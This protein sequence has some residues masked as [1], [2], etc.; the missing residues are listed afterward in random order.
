MPLI[1]AQLRTLLISSSFSTSCLIPNVAKT[2]FISY[3]IPLAIRINFTPFLNTMTIRKRSLKKVEIPP[4]NLL[5]NMTSCLGTIK[6][7]VFHKLQNWSYCRIAKLCRNLLLPCCCPVKQCMIDFICSCAH[8]II[9]LFVVSV[10]SLEELASLFIFMCTRGQICNE[11]YVVL[12]VQR[13][14]F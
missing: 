10:S 2:I 3:L 11:V 7:L 13:A 9:E 5:I 14:N 1:L 8:V 4:T 6:A 12:C